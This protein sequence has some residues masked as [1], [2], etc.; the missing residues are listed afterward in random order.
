MQNKPSIDDVKSYWDARPCNI[1]HSTHEIGTRSY[2]DDVERR[3]YFVEP[4]IPGFAEFESW[5]NKNVLEI[6]CGI[7][8]DG[9]NFARSGAH[10]SAIELSEESLNLTRKRF[11]VYGLKGNFVC[12][13]AENLSQHFEP[14]SF[15]MVYSF[16]V[17]HHTPDPASVLKEIR[18]VIAP[19]GELRIMLYAKN[20]WKAHMIS[21]G[22][23]QPEAQYGCPIANTYDEEDVRQL[24]SGFR[25]LSIHQDHIFPYK[26]D[27]YKQHQY[28]KEDW[29]AAMP[30]EMFR[31]LERR[32]GWHLLI[33]ATPE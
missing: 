14:E 9:I 5:N 23:D 3:K 8:T 21:E 27:A 32:M 33:R 25:I 10:Y 22:F 18:Q 28:I 31:A 29:F 11:A 20:S 6:G 30:D 24:L 17:I 1:R 4:H 26:V 7:G 2:F 15:D 12:N 19:D 13:N 16:G